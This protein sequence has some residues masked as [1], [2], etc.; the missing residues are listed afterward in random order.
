MHVDTKAALAP[1]PA[2][3]QADRGEIESGVRRLEAALNI[4]FHFGLIETRS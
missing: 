3:I 1:T 4:S 2:N